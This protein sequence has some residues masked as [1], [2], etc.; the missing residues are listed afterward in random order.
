MAAR[1]GPTSH[2][3][4]T[5]AHRTGLQASTISALAAWSL[6]SRRVARPLRASLAAPASRTPPLVAALDSA[7]LRAA[8]GRQRPFWGGTLWSAA[9]PE[10]RLQEL[11]TQKPACVFS[12]CSAGSRFHVLGTR[13][14]AHQ[15]HWPRIEAPDAKRNRWSVCCIRRP[16]APAPGATRSIGSGQYKDKSP[17]VAAATSGGR[18]RGR[19]KLWLFQS[20]PEGG[21]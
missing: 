15:N 14:Q 18:P 11:A 19:S 20:F 5:S 21:G 8:L 6:V 2:K 7:R 4:T 10:Q 17:S 3:A 1:R 12:A 9:A 16:G 13:P